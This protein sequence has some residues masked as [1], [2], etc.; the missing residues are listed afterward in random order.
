MKRI[1]SS[2]AILLLTGCIH[3]NP[4]RHASVL[5]PH[6]NAACVHHSSPTPLCVFWW[7]TASSDRPKG[8]YFV[9]QEPTCQVGLLVAVNEANKDV[10][11]RV[12]CEIE[13]DGKPLAEPWQSRWL[14]DYRADKYYPKDLI[15]LP[16]D[17]IHV[18]YELRSPPNKPNHS[19]FHIVLADL[20]NKS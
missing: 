11:V 16:D 19:H 5:A 20:F 12:H 13:R 1:F 2:V 17:R 3:G 18:S 6:S 4:R 7:G 15:L 8:D 14:G 9:I 10:E